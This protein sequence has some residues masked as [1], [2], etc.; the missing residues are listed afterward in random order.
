MS[1]RTAYCTAAVRALEGALMA[2]EGIDSNALMERAGTAAYARARRAFPGARRWI[3]LAGAG[4]NAGDGFV[5]ARLAKQEGL[6]ARVMLLSPDNR[7][8][9]DAATQF[10]AARQSAV[11]SGPLV[12]AELDGCDLIVD[13]MLGIGLDRPLGGLYLEAAQAVNEGSAPV[14]AVDIPTGIHADTG[15]SMTAAVRAALTVTFVAEKCGLFLGDAPDY[16]GRRV[17]EPL[18]RIEPDGVAEIETEFAGEP[19]LRVFTA[20]TLRAMLPARQRADHKGRFGHVLVVAGG[21]GMGGAA[22]LAG[23]GALRA[24]AGLVSVATHPEHAAALLSGR[25]ELMVRGVRN[26]EDL[27]PL[28]ERATVLAVG[29]GLGRDAWARELFAASQGGD[30]PVVVDADGLGLVPEAPAGTAPRILTPHP[31]EAGRLLDSSSDRVQDDRLGAVTELRKRYGGVALL[32]GAHT[33]VSGS[34]KPPWVI[35]AGNPGMAT[36]GMGDVLTG[37][38][39]GLWAQ[40]P[41]AEPEDLAAMAAFIHARAGDRAATAGQRGMIAGDLIEA[42]RAELNP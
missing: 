4:N 6:D 28:L 23:E 37:L 7:P 13:A 41:E 31:G 24:G 1:H 29:C 26:A 15:A 16:V 10:E 19:M 11:S 2:S 35:D 30:L 39:A 34:G 40:F 42:L 21:P 18:G 20:E 36:A 5:M 32:K 22:R 17:L 14:V 12:Q 25:P 3:V 27:A 38:M 33:L 8:R 9:G